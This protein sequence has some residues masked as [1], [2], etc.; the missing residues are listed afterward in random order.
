VPSS[1]NRSLIIDYS[2]H[3]GV[4]DY[5]PAVAVV[6]LEVE[7][8]PGVQ[9]IDLAVLL[10]EGTATEFAACAL[11]PAQDGVELLV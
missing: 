2:L 1:V 8:A 4:G 5:F 10:V 7:A 11:H 3:V 6:V 9:V